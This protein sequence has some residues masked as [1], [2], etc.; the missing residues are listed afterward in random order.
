M[1]ISLED[2]DFRMQAM[3]AC[4]VETFLYDLP[5]RHMMEL[6]A[7]SPLVL[8]RDFW[9]L[10]LGL[11]CLLL[12]F[13]IAFSLPAAAQADVRSL[14]DKRRIEIER[15]VASELQNLLDRMERTEGQSRALTVKVSFD[16]TG[17]ILIID[18]G[19]GFLNLRNTHISAKTEEQMQELTGT[20]LYLLDGIIKVTGTE[21]RFD[22]KD[23]YH[24]FPSE[25]HPKPPI[26]SKPLANGPTIPAK[27]V[28]SPSHGLYYLFHSGGGGEW[29][30]QRPL[31]NGIRE[32]YITPFLADSLEIWMHVRSGSETTWTRSKSF[33]I[34]K[35]SGQEWWRVAARG[36]L[37]Q[38]YPEHPEI[39]HSLPNHTGNDRQYDEDIRARPL[40]ANYLGADTLISLHTNGSE[41]T[42][43]RGAE[44]YA[45]PGREADRA[46][47]TSILCYMKEIIQ[48]QEG[49]ESFPVRSYA[50]TAGN[51][52]ENRLATMPAIVVEVAYHSNPADAA[53]LQDPVFQ[54]AAMKGIE[55]GYRLKAE[56]KPCSPFNIDNIPDTSGP[57]N[58][59]ITHTVFYNG[60]PQF[61]VTAEME[62]V[63]C[64]T[65]WY[66]NDFEIALASKA[67]SPLLYSTTCDAPDSEPS[68]TFRLKTTLID[69]DGVSTGPTEHSYTCTTPAHQQTA[70]TITVGVPTTGG[71]N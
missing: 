53:A 63:T 45:H 10:K 64:P 11:Q 27:V 16:S 12:A 28:I 19:K 62:Y 6:H 41:N 37:E 48:A 51:Y 25:W 20:A 70:G 35:P 24:Y 14:T 3:F 5:R 71:T 47:G 49:Y 34:H 50:S 13:V 31:L 59:P 23:I 56:N 68:A 69:A 26:R 54:T 55:K 9:L 58:T 18:P 40:F 60:Y 67:P 46:L 21:F 33:D 30:E 1:S 7:I 8:R 2:M 42:S 52:G 61:P 32:D 15:Q 29:I 66:C 22:G 4:R 65:G 38:T 44:A 17:E 36:H 43:I 57:H 39:W